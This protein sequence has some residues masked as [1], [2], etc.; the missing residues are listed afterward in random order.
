MHPLYLI[1]EDVAH[2]VRLAGMWREGVLPDAGGMHAQSAWL[3][4]AIQIVLRAW[5]QLQEAR[6]KKP[7]G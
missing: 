6:L 7:K 4:A 2:V 5:D 1:D 3:A